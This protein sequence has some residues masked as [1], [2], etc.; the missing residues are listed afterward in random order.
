MDATVTR[1]FATVYRGISGMGFRCD[2]YANAIIYVYI[3][4]Y[5]IPTPCG[6]RF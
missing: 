3:Y 2:V 4:I 5:V 6:G 1:G